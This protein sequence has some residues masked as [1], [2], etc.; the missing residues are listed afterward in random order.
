MQ[1]KEQLIDAD[2]DEI[3]DPNPR[4]TANNSRGT[5]PIILEPCS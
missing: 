2:I 3:K 5:V 1:E 4:S